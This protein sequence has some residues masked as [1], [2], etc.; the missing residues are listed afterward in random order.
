[1]RGRARR[2]YL[3][4]SRY[5]VKAYGLSTTM[6]RKSFTLVQVGPVSTRSPSRVKN[7]V[8]LLSARKWAGSRPRH[9]AR[10]S[11]FWSIAAPAGSSGAPAPPSVPS[12]SPA[13]AA[14]AADGYGQFTTGEDDRAAALPLQ[15]QRLRGL[16]C[17]DV[18]GFAFDPVAEHD[19]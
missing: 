1:M 3:L 15:R 6:A 10:A 11:V 17:R 12:V 8:E 7:P 18:T 19:A 13:A 14:L 5:R 4:A 16:V 9:C 2:G